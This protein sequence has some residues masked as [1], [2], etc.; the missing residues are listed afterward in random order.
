M[1]SAVIA[2]AVATGFVAA[3]APQLDKIPKC[4]YS[5]VSSYITGT[6]IAGCAPA[7]IACVCGNQEFLSGISCCL[8]KDCSK[9]DIKST[10]DFAAGLCNASGVKTP[11]ELICKKNA[12]SSGA[13]SSSSSG[14]A[15]VAA[16]PTASGSQTSASGSGAPAAS[17]TNAAAAPYA[18]AGGVLGAVVAVVALL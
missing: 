14:S 11:K 4:A 18:N 17:K 3:Q 6:N 5:C 16:T 2:L 10:I 12:A 7:D 1:K 9:D 8:E 15:A 13:S